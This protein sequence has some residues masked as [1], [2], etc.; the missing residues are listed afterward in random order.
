MTSFI[1]LYLTENMPM[2]HIIGPLGV[3]SSRVEGNKERRKRRRSSIK[4]GAMCM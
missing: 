3:D 1:L 2:Q 4:K